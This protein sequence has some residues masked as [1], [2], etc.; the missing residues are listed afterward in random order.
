MAKQPWAVKLEEETK[1]R[2]S[3]LQGDLQGEEFVQAMLDAFERTQKTEALEAPSRARK[4]VHL[5]VQQLQKGVDLLTS[6]ITIA[7]TEASQAKEKAS[8]QIAKAAEEA[9]RCEDALS[10]IK[11]QLAEKD[12][13]LATAEARIQELCDSL[14]QARSQAE[15]IDAI[16]LAWSEKEKNLNAQIV[17]LQKDRQRLDE[18]KTELSKLKE[19][20]VSLESDIIELKHEHEIALKE[21]EAAKITTVNTAESKAQLQVAEAE[22]KTKELEHA[23]GMEIVELKNFMQQE[24]QEALKELSAEHEADKRKMKT[25]I[26]DLLKS[27]NAAE[28]NAAKL[29]AENKS[30]AE[31][32]TDIK[33]ALDDTKSA[34]NDAKAATEKAEKRSEGLEAELKEARSYRNEKN[35]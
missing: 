19:K 22:S 34:L 32:I 14:E 2:I 9:S 12:D 23:H 30:S 20:V 35:S 4:E 26:D 18:A 21:V 13:D 6:T 17:D 15:S 27:K 7:E 11:D 33:S 5:F 10:Q 3:N 8:T 1:A 24:A 16:K 28:I 25:E 29:E 31:R